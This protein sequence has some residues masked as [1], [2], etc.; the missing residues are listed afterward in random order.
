MITNKDGIP[1][2]FL[3]TP[4]SVADITAFKMMD[5]DLGPKA[6][7]Y[8]DKA[9]TDYKFEDSLLEICNIRLVSER[10]KN[11]KRQLSGCLQYLLGKL[12]KKIETTFSQITR[13]LPRKIEAVTIRGFLIKVLLFICAFALKELF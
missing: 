13:L 9:Y 11:S 5:I 4:A 10:K 7:I 6:I 12:R 8:G 2:E 3:I 1:I